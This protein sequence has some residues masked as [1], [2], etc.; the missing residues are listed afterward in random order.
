MGL[1]I[2]KGLVVELLSISRQRCGPR[3]LHVEFGLLNRALTNG[4]IL[5]T[6]CGQLPFSTRLQIDFL[7]GLIKLN[8]PQPLIEYGIRHLCQ[9]RNI[10][11]LRIGGNID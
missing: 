4:I 11:K 3:K 2:S 7:L 8:L 9:G 5:G 1:G 6:N 10:L